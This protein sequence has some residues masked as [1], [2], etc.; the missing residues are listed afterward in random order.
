MK[1]D[2]CNSNCNPVFC[3]YSKGNTGYRLAVA[4]MTLF[5]GVIMI[6]K[7]LEK[8]EKI[9]YFTLLLHMVIWFSVFVADSAQLSSAT[10]A[11]SEKYFFF[12]NGSKCDNSKYGITIAIDIAICF[13]SFFVWYG[14]SYLAGVSAASITS[15]GSNRASLNTPA[16]NPVANAPEEKPAS[17]SWFA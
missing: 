15:G 5:L 11:C 17:K 12:I 13:V 3:G 9:K 8:D 7:V 2:G 16:P 14:L 10:Q 1:I 6:F 4:I